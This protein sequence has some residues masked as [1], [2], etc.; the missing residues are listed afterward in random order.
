MFNDKI[1]ELQNKILL[2]NEKIEI[3]QKQMSQKSEKIKGNT[4]KI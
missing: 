2:Q 4:E 3:L 1:C